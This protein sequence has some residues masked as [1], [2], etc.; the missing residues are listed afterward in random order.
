MHRYSMYI[1]RHFNIFVKP[2]ILRENDN[3]KKPSGY[4]TAT[5]KMIYF[6]FFL[7]LR[8]EIPFPTPSPSAEIAAPTNNKY[9]SG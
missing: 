7:R 3:Y 4:P 2:K 5:K 1:I 8:T 6:S 9:G